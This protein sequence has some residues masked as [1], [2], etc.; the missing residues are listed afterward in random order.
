[1]K[2]YPL[3]LEEFESELDTDEACR[4]TSLTFGEQTDLF[5]QSAVMKRHI[6]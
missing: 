3:T 5:V 6:Q 1:M 4:A 2:E